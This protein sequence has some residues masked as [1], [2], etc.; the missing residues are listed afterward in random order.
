MILENEI[1]VRTAFAIVSLK[2]LHPDHNWTRQEIAN[3]CA[4]TTS[5]IIKALAE[6][7]ER[8]LIEQTGRKIKIIDRAKLIALQDG[9]SA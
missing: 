9:D 3:F 1:L 2:D 4:S 5:T 7:E 6:F 8:G